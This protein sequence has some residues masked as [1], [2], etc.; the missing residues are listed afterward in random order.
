MEKLFSSQ[1]KYI[2]IAIFTTIT[3]LSLFMM[4]QRPKTDTV[5]SFGGLFFVLVP[6]CAASLLALCVERKKYFLW[7]KYTTIFAIIA[8]LGIFT[9]PFSDVSS[10]G[11]FGYEKGNISIV[12]ALTYCAFAVIFFI[13]YFYMLYFRK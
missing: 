6:V 7:A 9:A 3:L 10:G 13:H 4:N 5:F 12:F 1:F 8:A 11:M 2:Y